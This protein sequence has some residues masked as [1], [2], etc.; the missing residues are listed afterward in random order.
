VGPLLA[1]FYPDAEVKEPAPGTV[2]VCNFGPSYDATAGRAAD[3]TAAVT[4]GGTTRGSLDFPAWSLDFNYCEI[5]W[6]ATSPTDTAVVSVSQTAAAGTQ[7]S[8][9]AVY[10]VP[11]FSLTDVPATGTY[12]MLA[13]ANTGYIVKYFNSIVDVP[14]PPPPVGGQG[15]TPGYWKRPRHFKNWTLPLTPT[16]RFSTVFGSSIF[17]SMTLLDVLNE[18]GGRERALG[19]HAVAALLNATSAGVNY[20]LTEAQV[21]AEFLAALGSRT[22]IVTTKDRFQDFNQ[23]GCPLN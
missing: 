3:Y 23:Q 6:Q 9:M 18:G 20:D 5:V 2:V 14:P 4:G 8:R 19:R 12:Q 21:R 13:T 1:Y 16:S 15:C 17:G 11:Q 10:Q 22:T 7:V